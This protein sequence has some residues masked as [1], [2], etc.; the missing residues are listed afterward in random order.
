LPKH[1]L[2]TI[3][4]LASVEN[5]VTA[6]Q[7]ACPALVVDALVAAQHRPFGAAERKVEIRTVRQTP[8]FAACIPTTLLVPVHASVATEVGAIAHLDTLGDAVA[9]LAEEAV[10]TPNLT[11]G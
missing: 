6:V 10:R 5:P 2:V 9:T 11:V 3:A 4:K 8:E 7:E 1:K